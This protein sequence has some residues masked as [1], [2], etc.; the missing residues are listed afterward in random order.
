M[1]ISQYIKWL[2][3]LDLPRKK[4][5]SISGKII[6]LH[7]SKII[8]LI[9]QTPKKQVVDVGK[10]RLLHNYPSSIVIDLYGVHKKIPDI[11]SLI[12]QIVDEKNTRIFFQLIKVPNI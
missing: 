1:K 5:E 10:L 2:I 4:V 8:I 9:L 3:K 11:N 7:Y 6:L 12:Q